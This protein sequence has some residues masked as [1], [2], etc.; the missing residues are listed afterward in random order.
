MNTIIIFFR[1]ECNRLCRNICDVDEYY[2]IETMFYV[3]KESGEAY[4]YSLNDI[5]HIEIKK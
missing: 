2:C 4:Y 1:P 5:S 3:H